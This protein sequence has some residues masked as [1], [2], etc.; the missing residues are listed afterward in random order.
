MGWKDARLPRLGPAAPTRR[1]MLSGGAAAVVTSAAALVAACGP[2]TPA[3]TAAPAPTNPKTT[4]WWQPWRV[5]WGKGWDQI[6][7]DSTAPFRKENPSIDVRIDVSNSGS[8]DDNWVATQILTGTGPD[9]FSGYSPEGLIEKGYVLDITAAVRKANFDLGVFDKGQ[10]ELYRRPNG[11]FAL[12]AELS[13]SCMAVNEGILDDAGFDYPQ[14]GWSYTDAAQLWQRLTVTGKKSRV[15]TT[16]WA[17]GSDFA[18]PYF[19]KGWGA[20]IIDPTDNHKA[21]LASPAGIAFVEWLFPL[22]K[23]GVIGWGGGGSDLTTGKSATTT[24]GSWKLPYVATAWHGLKWDFYP[25]PV[26]PTGET[27]YAGR[28]YYAVASTSKHPDEA[29]TLLLWL[30]SSEW[31][32]SMMQLQL[33]VPS[34]RALWTEWVGTVGQI[35]PP[36]AKKHLDAFISG[37]TKDRAFAMY[38][39]GSSSDRAYGLIYN[40]MAQ[41][42]AGKVTPRS[43]V[44]QAA[45]QVDAFEQAQAAQSVAETHMSTLFPSNGPTI[46]TVTPGL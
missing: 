11:L 7:Y 20:D 16:F 42:G 19:W 17:E 34:I 43:G 4:L 12:P 6:F 26:W 37:A 3:R 27:A 38:A 29:M 33:V 23:A 39:F 35:A 13:T 45:D 18:G 8:S 30:M 46:A 41:I 24:L 31:Q 1:Q 15:G 28:D 9:V 2:A 25:N 5:G 40:W 44:Q 14:P 36:L 10:L 21:A 32:R 22:V